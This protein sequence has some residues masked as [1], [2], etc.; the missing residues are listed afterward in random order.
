MLPSKKGYGVPYSQYFSHSNSSFNAVE[1]TTKNISVS[2][3]DRNYV[4]MIFKKQEKS[5][6]KELKRDQMKNYKFYKLASQYFKKSDLKIIANSMEEPSKSHSDFD[7]YVLV[8]C[9]QKTG[10]CWALLT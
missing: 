2:V 4:T 10:L 7:S 5:W 1:Y 8:T 3:A 6:K 9:G